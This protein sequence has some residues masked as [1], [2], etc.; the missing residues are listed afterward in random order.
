MAAIP[1]GAM[2]ACKAMKKTPEMDLKVST[3]TPASGFEL[4]FG[5]NRKVLEN[6]VKYNGK[7]MNSIWGLYNRLS[8]HNI[9]K[10]CD[11]K[12][13]FNYGQDQQQ[14]KYN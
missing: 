10:S 12:M 4:K 3:T 7:M 9:K 8:P 6:P 11:A 2:A 5:N 1:Y 13:S 14:G